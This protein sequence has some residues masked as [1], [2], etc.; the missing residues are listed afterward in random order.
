MSAVTQE[1]FQEF[2]AATERQFSELRGQFQ[3]LRGQFQ[4]FEAAT[5]RQFSELRGEFQEFEAATQR[6]FQELREHIDAS[7]IKAQVKMQYWMIGLFVGAVGLMATIVSS[8]VSSLLL[9]F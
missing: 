7:I 2:E 9:R 4:E 3:E 8:F 5:E 6:Q 1:Q